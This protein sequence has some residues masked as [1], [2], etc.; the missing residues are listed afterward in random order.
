MGLQLP[1][2]VLHLLN[3]VSLVE[4]C[5]LASFN[6]DKAIDKPVIVIDASWLGYHLAMASGGPVGHVIGVT[7]FFSS[8]GWLVIPVMDG[9]MHHCSKVAS[10]KR[11][12][13]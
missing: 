5:V 3:K 10:V 13:K 9:P 6:S 2:L 7:K 4:L 11:E 12:G 1:K 8:N